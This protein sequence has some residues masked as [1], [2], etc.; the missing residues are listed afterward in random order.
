[1]SGVQ[2]ARQ[3]QRRSALMPSHAFKPSTRSEMRL[4][5]NGTSERWIPPIE[6]KNRSEVRLSGS[7]APSDRSETPIPATRARPNVQKPASVPSGS[8]N[9][10]NQPEGPFYASK[11]VAP[12]RSPQSKPAPTLAQ[13]A[14]VSADCPARHPADSRVH[15]P[16]DARISPCFSHNP[17]PLRRSHQTGDCWRG[18]A[19][20]R[21][22]PARDGSRRRAAMRTCHAGNRRRAGHRSKTRG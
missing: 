4:A 7:R 2:T 14:S 22:G 10:S 16:F 13:P 9:Q 1:M 8:P 15:T 6:T 17:E 3:Q 20:R 18:T 5:A 11:P 12:A 21:V 19:R